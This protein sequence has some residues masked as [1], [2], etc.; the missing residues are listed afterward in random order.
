M[1]VGGG[2]GGKFGGRRLALGLAA[3]VGPLA[4]S[5]SSHA[6]ERDRVALDRAPP[7][8]HLGA[9]AGLAVDLPDRAS[10]DHTRFGAGPRL[11]LP[12]RIGFDAPVRLRVDLEG[13]GA[14]GVDRLE[15]TAD[16]TRVQDDDTHKA[17]LG[18]IGLHGGADV[19]IPTGGRVQPHVGAS[20]G[21][22]G[23]GVFHALRGGSAEL[24]DPDQNDLGNPR[25]L[26]PHTVQVAVV[27][28]VALGL[29][30]TLSDR[31]DLL[32]ETGYA[33][34]FLPTAPLRRTA[35]VQGAE[36]SALAWNPFRASV[37]V[38]VR[39]GRPAGTVRQAR[40]PLDTAPPEPPHPDDT[41][42]PSAAALTALPADAP[43]HTPARPS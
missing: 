15:W 3:L 17:F 10:A 31:V 8:T 37:G 40:H 6:A 28:Q 30:A 42:S 1:R 22:A 5:A 4:L 2:R 25:N 34:A 13:E 39:L 14:G 38:L 9:A 26:D 41:T 35:E 16:D 20:I 23:V 29:V 27:P 11:V 36:R 43:V 24:L 32:V 33:G 19:V 18:L 21:V 7:S 12:L